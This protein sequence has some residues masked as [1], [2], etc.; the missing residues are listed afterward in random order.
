M[1][2]YHVSKLL[3]HIKNLGLH[4]NEKKSKLEPSQVTQFLGMTLESSTASISPTTQRKGAIRAC[5][6]HF[7]LNSR[8]S[9]RLCLGYTATLCGT[10][11]LEEPTEV[12]EGQQAG[13]CDA[14]ATLGNR[15]LTDRLGSCTRRPR[16]PGCLRQTAEPPHQCS[17]ALDNS[18]CASTIPPKPA[19]LPYNSQDQQHSGSS[20]CQQAGWTGLSP[21]G[22]AGP[23]IMDMGTPTVTL[24]E[25]YLPTRSLNTTTSLL[26]RGRPSARR[27][28][29]PSRGCCADLA[30]LWEGSIQPVCLQR[31]G[32]LSNVI[33]PGEGQPTTRDRCS[34]SPVAPR[35]AVCHSPFQPSPPPLM[36]DPT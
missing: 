33:L 4:I 8:V 25:R 6:H 21:T 36:E 28:G 3:L 13:P 16:C 12:G 23:R 17:R 26:S 5:L 11:L 1:C 2:H 27:V 9:W 30:P 10:P 34:C 14:S 32:S 29:A 24:T 31:D 22:A 35:P 19:D 15:W 18:P 20:L 7:H